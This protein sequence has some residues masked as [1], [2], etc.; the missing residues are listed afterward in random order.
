MTSRL[1]A[2]EGGGGGVLNLDDI[3]EQYRTGVGWP[4]L[5]IH[6]EVGL[7]GVGPKRTESVAS[8]ARQGQLA[9]TLKVHSICS[10]SAGLVAC[11]RYGY[12]W[13]WWRRPSA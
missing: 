11:P 12:A 4:P 8:S 13:R 6:L 7:I 3:V 2:N 1:T 10:A 9:D 5:G